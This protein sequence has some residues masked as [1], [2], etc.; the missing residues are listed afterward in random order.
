MAEL[1]DCWTAGLLLPHLVTMVGLLGFG[2]CRQSWVLYQLFLDCWSMGYWTW[3]IARGR[4][5]YVSNIYNGLVRLVYN[6][7]VLYC[8]RLV[9]H[10]TLSSQSRTKSGRQRFIPNRVQV[11]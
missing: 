10:N 5:G 2:L 3:T 8:H 1:L 4:L 11:G 9:E 6:E 7:I